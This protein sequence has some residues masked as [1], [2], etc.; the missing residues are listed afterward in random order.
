M[1]VECLSVWDQ[2]KANGYK[3]KYLS[4]LLAD[5]LVKTLAGSA[6]NGPYVYFT[7]SSPGMDRMKADIEAVQPGSAAK[8]NY[9]ALMG[10]TSTDMFI[11]ALKTGGREG[12]EQHHARQRTE[13]GV[14]NDL[15]DG[16]RDGCDPVPED[17][18]LLVSVVSCGL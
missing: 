2:L 8:I 7:A 13:G 16:R 17:D 5:V 1:T 3:G 18:R 6:A 4:G 10:Y 15:E 11:Q 14:D 9:G 12:Q